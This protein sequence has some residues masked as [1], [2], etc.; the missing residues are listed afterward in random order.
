MVVD[1]G[2]TLVY[3]MHT[4][5][6]RLAEELGVEVFPTGAGGRF[7]YYADDTAHTFRF[8]NLRG[9]RLLM[10]FLRVV[11]PLMRRWLPV[12]PDALVALM[13]T[14]RHLDALSATVPSDEPWTAP[15]AADL[16][17]RT[18]ASWLADEV[19]SAEARQFFDLFFGYLP[20]SASMLYALFFLRSWR[21]RWP[22]PWVTGSYWTRRSRRSTGGRTTSWCAAGMW[23]SRRS[24]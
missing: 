3:P 11:L 16:D 6:L 1:E 22:H 17:R 19:R 24:G 4:E 5:V 15:D 10:P 9:T 13:N 20:R 18:L 14:I 21:R 7:L 23:S 2:A 12:S 8:G